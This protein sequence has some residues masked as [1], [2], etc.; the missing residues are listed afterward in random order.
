MKVL[1]VDDSKAM[2]MILRRQLGNSAVRGVEVL[3]AASGVEA[4][5]VLARETVD[6]VMSDWNM[7]EMNGMELLQTLRA[8]GNGVRFGFVTSETQ[9]HVK[10][11]AFDAGAMFVDVKPFTPMHSTVCCSESAEDNY[12]L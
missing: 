11:A 3:E 8:Q 7:P 4:L 1:V 12:A 5:E 10:D 9:S 6:L 2:R